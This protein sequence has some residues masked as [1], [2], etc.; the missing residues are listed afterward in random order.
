MERGLE[1]F[2]FGL[3]ITDSEAVKEIREGVKG[4]EGK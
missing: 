3:R 2:W 4:F 1:I